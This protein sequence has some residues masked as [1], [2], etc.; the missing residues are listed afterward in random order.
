MQTSIPEIPIKC[1][2]NT[3]VFFELS[4]FRKKVRPVN[5]TVTF[6]EEVNWYFFTRVSWFFTFSPIRRFICSVLGILRLLISIM[7][8]NLSMVV[9]LCQL[10]PWVSTIIMIITAVE[11][12]TI[13]TNP[14]IHCVVAKGVVMI[15]MQPANIVIRYIIK[16][17]GNIVVLKRS[18][19]KISF[20]NTSLVSVCSRISYL[21]TVLEFMKIPTRLQL[22]FSFKNMR[23]FIDQV[24]K[25][26]APFPLDDVLH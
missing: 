25:H 14:N 19:S 5:S 9:V 6:F 4:L 26:H 22:N 1:K 20:W 2:L 7:P 8:P 15:I 13:R 21:S 16:T 11:P 12:V 17:T 10:P 18:S 23:V 24:A 3:D